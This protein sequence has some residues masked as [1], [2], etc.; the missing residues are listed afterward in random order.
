MINIVR[1]VKEKNGED[2][3]LLLD[4]DAVK[5]IYGWSILLLDKNAGSFH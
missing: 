3:I 2:D 1:N 5:D 4:L